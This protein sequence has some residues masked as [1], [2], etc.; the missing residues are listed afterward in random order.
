MLLTAIQ[1]D[2]SIQNG[3]NLFKAVFESNCKILIQ[4]E[5]DRLNAEKINAVHLPVKAGRPRKYKSCLPK[6]YQ[7]F[8]SDCTGGYSI[9]R[10]N[11]DISIVEGVYA[12]STNF[13]DLDRE[14]W[15]G[16]KTS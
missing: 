6:S 15:H 1:E 13:G 12:H 10:K 2:K 5:E 14:R 16:M 4:Q 3:L 8:L 9:A 7:N 11:L